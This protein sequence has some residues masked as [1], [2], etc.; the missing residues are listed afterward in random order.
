MDKGFFC[1]TCVV[2]NGC[3]IETWETFVHAYTASQA[4]WMVKEYWSKKDNETFASI[5]DCRLVP[6]SE[7][8]AMEVKR[9]V[10]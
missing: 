4:K 1:V 2:D 9:Y 5:K 8:I 3:R 10:S 6:E 7:I